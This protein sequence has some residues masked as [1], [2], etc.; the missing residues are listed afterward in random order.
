M[1][2]L[3]A[4][5]LSA[6]EAESPIG[7]TIAGF[8]LPDRLGAVHALEDFGEARLV[9]IAFLGTECP[10]AEQYGPRLVE[11]ADEFR[12]R[13]VAFVGINSNQQDSLADME[14]YELA[15]DISFPL[16]KDVG[17]KVADDFGA[18]R[19]PEVFVLDAN[20]VV[21]YWGRIDDQ[22]GVGYKRPKPLRR[23][24][25]DAL[26]QLLAGEPV[27]SPV[28]PSVGCHIGRVV[29]QPARGTVVYSNQIAPIFKR[30]CVGCH[31]SGDIAPFPLTSYDEVAGWAKTIDEVIRI[32]RMPPWHA[33]PRFGKFAN[34]PRMTDDEK[35]LVH[36]WVHNGAPPGESPDLPKRAEPT[37]R[38]RIG[39]PDLVVSMPQSFTVPATGIVDY[40]YFVVDPGFEE[41]KWVQA[42]EVRPGS[43]AVVHHTVVFVQ[44]P[45]RANRTNPAGVGLEDLLGMEILATSVPGKLTTV[46]PEGIARYVAAGSK[47]VFQ[48]HYTPSGRVEEDRT[49]VGL[50]FADANQVRKELRGQYTGSLDFRIPPGASDHRIEAT[51][52]FRQDRLLYSLMPHMHLRGKSFRYEALYPDGRQ[53]VLLD[54]PEYDFEWQHIYELAQP[55][56]M[57]EGTR[58]HCTAVFDNSAENLWN[59]DP[60]ATVRF[61][62]QTSEEMM[63]GFFET[64]LVEQDLLLPAPEV[65][66]LDGGEVF[67]VRFNYRPTAPAKTVSLVG[68]FNDWKR[69]AQVMSP[70]ESGAF[71]TRLILQRGRYEYKF[72]IGS[73]DWK[74]DPANRLQAGYYNNSL[75]VVGDPSQPRS[76]RLENGDF[77]VEFK[78]L[79]PE[80]ASVHLVGTFNDWKAAEHRMHGPDENGLFSTHLQLKRG[81][82]QYKF[83]VDGKDW[84]HDPANP[85]LIEKDNNSLLQ[86]R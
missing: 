55:Q 38:W 4:T 62:L 20:R 12:A 36:Q 15:H 32:G 46:L 34:D 56:L 70:D 73:E 76:R 71:T 9:V 65:A 57:P 54:V 50:L 2:V 13:Q 43:R 22:Y 64:A 26:Q 28:V 48:M 51:H 40:Q 66:P 18:V 24:L 85:Q 82:H 44:P 37:A 27:N 30:R 19:T 60:T 75:L 67:E 8:R 58:L 45:G 42:S 25:A 3:C 33:N 6:A 11:L 41:D 79:A 29:K 35:Q 31:R 47:L 39:E 21:R 84:R 49:K 1:V 68:S 10:L 17:N 80:A 61:G 74:H 72:L 69:E 16:V 23:D 78:F 52:E 77:R 86:L 81:S 53:E 59:P 83:V 63:I 14:R 5:R 7:R